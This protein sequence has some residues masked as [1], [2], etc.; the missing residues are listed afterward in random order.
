MRIGN[1]F[2]KNRILLY[3]I[4]G[5]PFTSQYY[6]PVSLGKL[7]IYPK[8]GNI[9]HLWKIP[10][11]YRGFEWPLRNNPRNPSKLAASQMSK[12]MLIGDD[13]DEKDFRDADLSGK[14]LFVTGLAS[15][16]DDVRLYLAFE[17]IGFLLEAHV[18]KPGCLHRF[19][20]FSTAYFKR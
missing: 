5:L 3:F 19:E 7:S 17:P 11:Q 16:V 13:E 8:S 10:A 12:M 15:T 14:R 4:V 20:S 1:P 2:V 18:V 9:C 6:S